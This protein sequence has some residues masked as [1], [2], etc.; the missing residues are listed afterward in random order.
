MAVGTGS[1][2]T[3]I[4]LLISVHTTPL[5]SERATLLKSVVVA[6]KLGSYAIELA[7]E[8]S[9]KEFDPILLCH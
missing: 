8:I 4:K 3:V 2:A 5:N 9:V 1:T 6:N 7:D